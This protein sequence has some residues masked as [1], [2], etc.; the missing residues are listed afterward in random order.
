MSI[1]NSVKAYVE[2]ASNG[3]VTA[4]NNG[5]WLSAYAIY[6]GATTI[7]NGSWLQTVC[8]QLGITS[9]VNG[10]WVIA[11]ANHYGVTQPLNGTWWFAIQDSVCTAPPPA[12]VWNTTTTQWQLETSTWN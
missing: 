8:D 9:P 10:S 1:S 11:L 2:C 4:P 3:N 6:L 7:K 12:L 5:G